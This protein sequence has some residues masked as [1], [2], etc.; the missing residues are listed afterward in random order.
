VASGEY[1]VKRHSVMQGL[2]K[3]VWV[4][5]LWLCAGLRLVCRK[6]ESTY[7]IL[8][9]KPFGNWSLRR[10]RRLILKWILEKQ[11][12]ELNNTTGSG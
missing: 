8:T 6:Q 4:V 2:S 11:V 9:G 3:I 7:R 5:K 1:F 12:E 10:Q